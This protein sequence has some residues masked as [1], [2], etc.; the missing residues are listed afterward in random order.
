MIN[1]LV[2]QHISRKLSYSIF[3]YIH[4]IINKLCC[5]NTCVVIVLFS[6]KRRVTCCEN[7]SIVRCWYCF[8]AV[9]PEP[10]LVKLLRFLIYRVLL[11]LAREP[12]RFFLPHCVQYVHRKSFLKKRLSRLSIFVFCLCYRRYNKLFS[13]LTDSILLQLYQV[14]TQ[15]VV[16]KPLHYY[17]NR[18]IFRII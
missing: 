17:D 18:T 9:I 2:H 13:F 14:S 15:V 3:Q 1:Y 10:L 7:S 5:H 12:Y 11:V 4:L 8:R 6:L 16:M